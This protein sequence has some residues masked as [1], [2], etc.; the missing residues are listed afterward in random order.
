[1]IGITN[2]NMARWH[3]G[4]LPLRM[5]AQAKIRITFDEH[6]LVDRAV[7]VMAN[8]AT[9]VHRLVLKDERARLC[10]V[11][12]R[13]ALILTRHRQTA[14]RFENVAAVGVVA[15][16]AIHMALNDGMM[17]RQRELRV[18]IQ[19]ALKTGLRVFVGINNQFGGTTGAN[20]LAARAV[21]GFAPALIAHGTVGN[22]QARMRAHREF[23]DNN[24]MAI[25]AG[26]IAHEMRPGNF[27]RRDE[28]L[29]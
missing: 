28:C 14:S 8:T 7:W 12:L 16:H 25:R 6:L 26:L 24:R 15:I 18:S 13:A 1:M 17:L 22:M 11:T 23:P 19:V 20:V 2:V 10:P 9:L 4:A 3:I 27:Q 29:S 5:A 21:A